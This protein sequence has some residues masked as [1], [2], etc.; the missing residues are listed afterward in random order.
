MIDTYA[1]LEKPIHRAATSGFARDVLIGLSRRPKAL[2]SMYFYDE[3]GSRLFQRI[4]ELEEYYLTRAERQILETYASHLAAELSGEPFRL[5]ELGAGD[6]GKTKVLLR[7]FLAAALQFEYMPVDICEEAL[8]ELTSSLHRQMADG[9]MRVHGIVAE[10]F[11]ALS[12]LD[13]RKAV[14]TLVLFLGS[15]IGNFEPLA[16]RRF[17]RRVRRALRPGDSFL[18]G[19]DLKKDPKVLTRA[20]NDAEGVTREFNFNLLRRI[21]RE[22]GGGFDR[23]RF[24]HH[25]VYN[26]RLGRMESWLVSLAD[27]QVAIGDLD[28]VFSLRRGEGIHVECSY[29]YD[30]EQIER[31]AARSGFE[32]R[33]HFFDR[34]HWF[35]DSLWRATGP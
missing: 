17:L 23:E 5:V 12:L 6:G 32:V 8:T 25:G 7:H 21:N 28:R 35:V 10:Y 31:L 16:A 20:Y 33:R 11:D 1:V 2:P 24:R 14:R 29:K 13:Q 22:L 3:N 19:F 27:Q 9:E 15:N 34:R 4:T 26:P 30:L 18:I